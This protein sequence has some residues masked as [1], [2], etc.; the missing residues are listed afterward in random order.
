MKSWPLGTGEGLAL[1]AQKQGFVCEEGQVLDQ[2]VGMCL[3]GDAGKART[4]G[5]GWMRKWER[6]GLANR[7]RRAN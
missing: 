1:D 4:S 7:R 5:E 6:P 2:C 3:E